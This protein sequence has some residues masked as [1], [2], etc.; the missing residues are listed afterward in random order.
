MSY[1]NAEWSWEDGVL[2]SKGTKPAKGVEP[3]NPGGD[4]GGEGG[5]GAFLLKKKKRRKAI[6]CA[7]DSFALWSRKFDLT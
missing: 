2:E 4:G 7:R 6:L 3:E 5:V 1:T